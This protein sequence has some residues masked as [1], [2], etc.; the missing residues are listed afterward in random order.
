LFTGEIPLATE[1]KNIG[2]VAPPFSYLDDVVEEMI[3]Q[4]PAKRPSIADIKNQ[5][6]ARKQQ[7]NRR[8][9]TGWKEYPVNSDWKTLL[10]RN[11]NPY[12]KMAT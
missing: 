5:L 12:S 10:I 8:S 2:A 7:F 11:A 9:T 3:R 4:D 1:F 6:I